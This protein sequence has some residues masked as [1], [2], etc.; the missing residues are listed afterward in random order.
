MLRC[1]HDIPLCQWIIFDCLPLGEW[2]PPAF[3]NRPSRGCRPRAPSGVPQRRC[4]K[5]LLEFLSAKAHLA[6]AVEEEYPSARQRAA[7]QT[8]L[9]RTTFPEACPWTLAQIP[10]DDFFPES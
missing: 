9:P 6:T 7:T 4:K 5:G 1:Y 2:K 3:H 10:D 8:G